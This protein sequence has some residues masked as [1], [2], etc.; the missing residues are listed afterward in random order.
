MRD[1]ADDRLPTL[2]DGD[3]LHRDL[4]FSSGSIALE[5]F[6][7][8]CEGLRKSV[9]SAFG[10][11]LLRDGFNMCEAACKSQGCHVNDSHLRR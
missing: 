7:L 4:L 8:G 11:I 3:M 1:V 10:A 6:E 5:R 9:E 2:I